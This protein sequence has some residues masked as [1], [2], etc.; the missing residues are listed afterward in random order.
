[1]NQ[2]NTH[3]NRNLIGGRRPHK[4]ITKYGH[5]KTLSDRLKAESKALQDYYDRIRK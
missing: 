3:Y 4:K 1:M 5:Y 2:F